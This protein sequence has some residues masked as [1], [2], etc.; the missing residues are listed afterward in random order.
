[1]HD[2][3]VVAAGPASPPSGEA[4]EQATGEDAKR[5]PPRQRPVTCDRDAAERQAGEHERRCRDRAQEEVRQDGSHATGARQ[6]LTNDQDADIGEAR[7]GD[8]EPRRSLRRRIRRRVRRDVRRRNRGSGRSRCP[9][10]LLYRGVARLLYRGVGSRR[11]RTAPRDRVKCGTRWQGAR[12]RTDIGNRSPRRIVDRRARRAP[13]R[14]GVAREP[15]HHLLGRL[16]RHVFIIAREAPLP[17]QPA[18]PARRTECRHCAC[19]R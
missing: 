10:R 5:P 14:V 9:A 3:P 11:R 19:G 2:A 15:R 17:M 16:L 12:R 1:M 8:D 6:E 13:Q 4:T 18:D 7:D